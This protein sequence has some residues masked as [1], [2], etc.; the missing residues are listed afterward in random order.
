MKSLIVVIILALSYSSVASTEQYLNRQEFAKRYVETIA[1]IHPT[2]TA[3][4]VGD[5][6]VKIKLPNNDEL[7]SFL[8][9]AYAE[10]KNSPE[11]IDGVLTTYAESII[12]PDTLGKIKPNKSQIFPVIKDKHYVVQ[13]EKML[14]NSGNKGLVYEKLNDILYV[15]YA[16]DTPKAIRFMTGSDLTDLALEKSELRSLSKTNLKSAHT[17]VRLEGDPASLSVL[18]AD[19]T[20]EAS[21]IL[22]DDIWTK[23]Q[24]PVMGNIVV[25]IPT[26]DLVFVT[27]SED[28][29]NLAKVQEI[30]FNQGSNWSHGISEVG[31]VRVNNS[32]Q[33]FHQ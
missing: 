24:F 3:K 4:V 2:A 32:W 5:L 19:G 9:N 30:F 8:D 31:F 15:L 21:F 16:F 20:Y 1:K 6:E 27:G 13:A 17:N 7:T 29:E 28:K 25:Y 14:E 23:E 10:Y 18:V 12:F 33:E 22:F 11:D 26:R